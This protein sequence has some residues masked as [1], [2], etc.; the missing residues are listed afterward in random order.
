MKVLTSMK[1]GT[2]ITPLLLAVLLKKPGIVKFLL[3]LGAR[4]TKLI[5][6]MWRDKLFEAIINESQEDIQLAIHAGANVNDVKD[7]IAPLL[8]A[9]LLRKPEI[10]KFLL[11][12]GAQ[13]NKLI[14]GWSLMLHDV[15]TAYKLAKICKFDLDTIYNNKYTL[16][17][18]ALLDNDIEV[19]YELL[20]DGA[21]LPFKDQ[22]AQD[23]GTFDRWNC[24]E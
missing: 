18:Y 8:L 23:L 21:K 15:K 4:P 19:L 3:H 17:K 16:L 9:V 1:L 20:K 11:H 6:D 24:S 2:G 13:P 10:V 14:I 5:I 22:K 12:L 7:G